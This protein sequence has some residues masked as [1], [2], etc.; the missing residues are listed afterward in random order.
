MITVILVIAIVLGAG[1]MVWGRRGHWRTPAASGPPAGLTPERL[2][3][4]AFTHGNTCLAAG[5]F[6]EAIAAFQQARELDPK[7]P[8]VTERLA[9]VAR[10]QHA[11]HA[12]PPA[13]APF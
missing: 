5:Q 3:F 7:R 10:R 11:A 4:E 1:W 13:A 8:H 9:E 6:A 2:A 12:T